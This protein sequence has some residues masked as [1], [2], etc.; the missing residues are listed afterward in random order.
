MFSQNCVLTN[1]ALASA[2]ALATFAGSSLALGQNTQP[3]TADQKSAATAGAPISITTLAVSGK[4]VFK[5]G[6]DASPVELKPGQALTEMAEVFTGPKT[7]VQIKVGTGQVYTIDHT[8]R[9]LIKDAVKPATGKETTTLEVPYGRVRFDITSTKVA[10]DVKIQTPDA[11]LAVKGTHGIIEKLPGQSTR[12]YGGELNTGVFNVMHSTGIKVDV[13]KNHQTSGANAAT[14]ATAD[15]K[16]FVQTEDS[17]SADKG[18]GGASGWTPSGGTLEEGDERNINGQ[19][20]KNLFPPNTGQNALAGDVAVGIDPN[21]GTV[22]TVTGANGVTSVAGSG[23]TGFLG[24][25][26]G[27]A[28][29][30]TE[31]GPYLVA[32]DS[33]AGVQYAEGTTALR[34]WNPGDRTWMML[35]TLGPLKVFVPDENGGH[36]VQSGYSFDGLGNLNGTLYASGVNP[37]QSEDPSQST[38]NFG[39]FQLDMPT[40]QRGAMTARQMMSFPMLRAG[41]GL[42]GAN[43]RGSMFAAAQFRNTDGSASGLVLLEIDPRINYVVNAWSAIEGDFSPG[44][45]GHTSPG[46]AIPT[47]FHPS[48]VAFVGGQVI[49]AGREGNQ[50]A[51]YTVRPTTGSDRFPTV[52]SHRVGPTVPSGTIAGEGGFAGSTPFPLGAADR[53]Y[54]RIAGVDPLWLGTAYSRNAARSGTF[55]RMVTDTILNHSPETRAYVNTPEFTAAL[56]NAIADHYNQTDG[57]N[58]AIS[59]FYSTFH[60]TNP[61]ASRPFAR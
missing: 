13:T 3:A 4:A 14:A 48:G 39:V 1:A 32:I 24:T 6:P 31:Y 42:T 47:T 40:T 37:A 46:N 53:N 8:T 60:V 9:V 19:N 35:G 10:N 59:Q 11:T 17:K 36:F 27:A 23:I 16:T 12:A 20:F 54:A 33:E 7:I 49:L 45:A 57:V 26:Q 55:R 58:S 56:G 52:T 38:G 5:S 41:G 28:L 22:I 15:A 61:N 30:N 51:S 18:T 34:F 50:N 21:L 2:V 44:N 43:S 29:M 25:P